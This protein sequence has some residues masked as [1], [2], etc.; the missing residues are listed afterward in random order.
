MRKVLAVMLSMIFVF[1]TCQAFCESVDLSAFTDDE[2]RL[3]RQRIDVELSVRSASSILEGGV[4]ATGDLGEYNVSILGIKAADDYKG[5]PCI[6]V[7]FLFVNNSAD[8]AIFVTAI[9]VDAFQ[10]ANKLENAMIMD[11]SVYNSEAYME[12]V[13]PGASIECERAFVLTD[14]T[15]PVEIQAHKL[16][17]FSKNPDQVIVTVAIPEK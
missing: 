4:L 14:T 13:Q 7:K 3:L 2:L 9:A 17:D 10:G 11:S 15:S 8:E 16:I 1:S 12:K 6:V 5:D